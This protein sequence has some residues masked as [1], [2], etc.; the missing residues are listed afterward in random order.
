MTLGA[1]A[2]SEGAT[3]AMQDRVARRRVCLSDG[4]TIVVRLWDR[5]VRRAL[6]IHHNIN[7]VESVGITVRT[8]TLT[9]ST[10]FR[11]SQGSKVFNSFL[12]IV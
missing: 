1:F 10:L 12:M 11:F 6:Q 7:D 3:D 5:R 8:S 2:R 9:I 4:I